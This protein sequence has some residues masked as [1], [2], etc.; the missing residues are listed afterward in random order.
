M[1]VSDP[2]QTQ[3]QVAPL[4]IETHGA[5]RLLR[6]NRPRKR[7]AMDT[8]LVQSL[9]DAL[10][11][12]AASGDVRAVVLAGAGSTFCAGGDLSEFKD[13]GPEDYDRIRQRSLMISNVLETLTVLPQPV[14][15]AVQ[16]YAYGGG[17][18][19]A[20]NC[21]MLVLS[22]DAQI[23]Y[24][25]LENGIVPSLVLAGVQR[26]VGVK[27]AFEALS[28][29]GAMSADTA[30][31]LGLANKVVPAGEHEAAALEIAD[32]LAHVDASVMQTF[33]SLFYRTLDLSVAQAM[34]AA[35]D[36]NSY[37]H[38]RKMI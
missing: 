12:I 32:R 13:L 31:E 11:D 20:L 22:P 26:H 9:S 25:E 30:L 27:R 6:L 19:L 23:S 16:G 7:N 36:V 8:E 18:A 15:G 10:A 5:I 24:P 37:T 2:T 33:K 4:T 14:V 38:L 28:I 34:Q 1:N 21:D 29:G 35:R 3:I 17:A